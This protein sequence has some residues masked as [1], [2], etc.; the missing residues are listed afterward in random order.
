MSEPVAA[1]IHQTY[2][3]NEHDTVLSEVSAVY[4][5]LMPRALL[6]AGIDQAGS[7]VMARHSSYPASKPAW[8]EAF[9]EHE[10][11]NEPLLGV[12]QQVHGVFVGS[13]EELLVPTTLFDPVAT[14]SWMESLHAICP[15][16]V[17]CHQHVPSLDAEHCFALPARFDKLLHRYFG[18]TPVRHVSCYQFHKPS[19]EAPYVVQLLISEGH[20]F[21]SLHGAGKLLWHQQFSFDNVEEIAW[22]IT[23]LG[24]DL[25]IRNDDLRV[26]L[27]MLNPELF[28]LGAEL[29]CYYR[30]IRWTSGLTDDRNPWAPVLYFLQQLYACAL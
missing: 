23:S 17:V 1:G 3:A 30:R 5:V 28:D 20:A 18:H 25:K 7:V 19:A 10:F 16:D 9:F 24:Q 26:Q 21:A 15:D 29:E 27:S 2:R 4:C 12:P 11:Q 22:R 13:T 8:D 14:K 6:V